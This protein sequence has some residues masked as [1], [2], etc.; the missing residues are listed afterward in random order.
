MTSIDARST[1]ETPDSKAWGF[2]VVSAAE[3]AKKSYPPVTFLVDGIL[4]P[5][6]ALLSAPPKSGKSW[7]AL[8]LC[9]CVASGKPFL[10]F[11]THQCATLYAGLEDSFQRLQGRTEKLLG[12]SV[13]PDCYLV[14][15]ACQIGAGLTDRIRAFKKAHPDLGLVVLDLFAR[16][17]DAESHSKNAYRSDYGEAAALKKV[18]DELKIC[19]LAVTHNR[20]MRDETDVFNNISGTTGLFGAADTGMILQK[21]R[22]EDKRAQLHI[23]GKDVEMQ[24]LRIEQ[25]ENLRWRR[26]DMTQEEIDRREQDNFEADPLVKTII[27]L[28]NESPGRSVEIPVGKLFEEMGSRIGDY[29]GHRTST[30]TKFLKDNASR[31]ERMWIKVKTGVRRASHNAVILERFSYKEE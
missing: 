12:E 27:E 7:L 1:I 28:L 18:A 19:I 29:A 25:D 20:K 2:E 15:E 9:L 6:F 31:F 14:T 30:I 17:R 16:V 8:Y 23:S 13:P 11:E 3:L 21:E 4:P 5:G 22:R 10:G 26:A 24:S